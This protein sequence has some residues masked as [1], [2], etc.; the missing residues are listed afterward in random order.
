MDKKMYRA[1]LCFTEAKYAEVKPSNIFL[2]AISLEKA[3]EDSK[4]TFIKEMVAAGINSKTPFTCE[5]REVSQSEV[6]EYQKNMQ[7]GNVSR[8]VN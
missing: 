5:V 7:A 8:M 2:R 1:T 6:E 4:S 3:M